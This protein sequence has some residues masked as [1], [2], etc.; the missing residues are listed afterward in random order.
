MATNLLSFNGVTFKDIAQR[1]WAEVR[2][3][4]V[5]GRSAQLAYYFLLA[6]F[7]FLIMRNRKSERGRER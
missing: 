6:L 4:D 7:P 1:T 2:T 5:F 3:D